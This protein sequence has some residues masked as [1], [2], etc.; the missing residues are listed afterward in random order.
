V[1]RS[2]DV[3]EIAMVAT[4]EEGKGWR[5]GK[6]YDLDHPVDTSSVL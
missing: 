6:I 4:P 2:T 1:L 3:T 5:A